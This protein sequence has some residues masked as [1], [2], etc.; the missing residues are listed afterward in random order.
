[1]SNQYLNCSFHDTMYLLYPQEKFHKIDF[2]FLIFSYFIP[3][4]GVLTI[5]VVAFS[6]KKQRYNIYVVYTCDNICST[7]V[8]QCSNLE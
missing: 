1:M 3:K 6:N 7:S 4:K 2:F 5:S 8:S